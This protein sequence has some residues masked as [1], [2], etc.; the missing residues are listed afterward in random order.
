MERVKRVKR[1]EAERSGAER[2][3]AEWSGVERSGAERSGATPP[4]SQPCNTLKTLI[5]TRAEER[6]GQ[7]RVLIDVRIV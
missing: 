3:G 6:S 7:Q 2:S 1:S 4:K 5:Q